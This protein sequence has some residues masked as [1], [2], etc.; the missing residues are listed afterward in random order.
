MFLFIY[1]QRAYRQQFRNWSVSK[2]NRKERMPLPH[3]RTVE[4]GIR[5]VRSSSSS[6]M[7]SPAIYVTPAAKTLQDTPR[8][9]QAHIARPD[10]IHGMP[11]M[12]SPYSV[13]ASPYPSP[14]PT[15]NSNF[16][17]DGSMNHTREQYPYHGAHHAA[18]R[19]DKMQ[20]SNK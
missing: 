4:K 19:E 2:Y 14:I 1:R 5:R 7:T 13:V 17:D 9:D 3:H 18:L 11:A 16:N 20:L 6:T 12:A 15:P 8:P 10:S